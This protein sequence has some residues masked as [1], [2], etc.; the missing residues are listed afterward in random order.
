MLILCDKNIEYK[1]PLLDSINS[2]GREDLVNTTVAE[3]CHIAAFLLS[4]IGHLACHN[5]LNTKLNP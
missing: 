3:I 4:L 5:V 1:V 2:K